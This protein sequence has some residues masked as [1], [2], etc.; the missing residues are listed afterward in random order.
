MFDSETRLHVNAG[1]KCDTFQGHG[2]QSSVKFLKK[3]RDGPVP[4][5]E[6]AAELQGSK[7]SVTSLSCRTVV[8]QILDK[9]GAITKHRWAE[10]FFGFSLQSVRSLLSTSASDEPR[11]KRLR[12]SQEHLAAILVRLQRVQNR[13]R[14]VT[15][16][17][18]R[19]ADRDRRNSLIDKAVLFASFNDVKSK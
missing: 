18:H 7:T 1:E 2:L 6:C 5:Y 15:S 9:V 17:L 11:K 19:Q 12:S 8:P 10:D 16:G 13:G 14:G 4:L 3:L